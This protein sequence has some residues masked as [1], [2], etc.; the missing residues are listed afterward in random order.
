MRRS[1][2]LLRPL[3]ESVLN[4]SPS[5]IRVP[6]FGGAGLVRSLV[7]GD[8]TLAPDSTD[9]GK[10]R[11][12]RASGQD[13]N[14]R[15]PDEPS[16]A[17]TPN[18]FARQK[19][20]PMDNPGLPEPLWRALDRRLWHATGPDCLE[21]IVRDGEV[22]SPATAIEAPC[23]GASIVPPC[24]TLVR[25]PSIPAS[26]ET[27]AAGSA[28]SRTLASPSGLRS[29]VSRQRRTSSKPEKCARYGTTTIWASS[30]F[31]A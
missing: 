7:L 24:S 13:D 10:A 16:P 15:Y 5:S 28:I 18:S 14:L 9:R 8:R 6:R 27:G 30:T 2:P 31:P 22:A 20:A 29:I 21:G 19:P 26:S 25:P 3:V 17:V 11:T 4:R 1:G 23:A 12:W